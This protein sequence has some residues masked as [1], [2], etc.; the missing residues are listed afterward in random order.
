[1]A[2]AV[3]IHEMTSVFERVGRTAADQLRY[4][5]QFRKLQIEAGR[6]VIRNGADDI[7]LCEHTNRGVAFGPDN[8]LDYERTD[9]VGAHQPGGNGDGFIHSNRRNASDFFAQ[10]ISDL[11][12]NPPSV[13]Y[14][15]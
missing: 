11:H 13:F 6:A 15:I 10:D 1:M 9:I 14:A 8:I 5:N 7:A 4:G 2:D 3:P 12:R